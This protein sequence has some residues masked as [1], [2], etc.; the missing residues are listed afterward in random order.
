MKNYN[1][2]LKLK[3]ILKSICMLQFYSY[4]T[5]FY[6]VKNGCVTLFTYGFWK[7]YLLSH[8]GNLQS[9]SHKKYEQ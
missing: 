3:N 9:S 7:Y 1:T 5:L 8:K 2:K 4:I 6:T